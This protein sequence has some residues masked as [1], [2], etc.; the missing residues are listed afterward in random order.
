MSELRGAGD[1]L[2]GTETSD[3]VS[4]QMFEL[5][6][7][8]QGGC[9]PHAV[10]LRLRLRC[11]VVAGIGG[12]RRGQTIRP[13]LPTGQCAA[14]CCSV[15][16]G[17]IGHAPMHYPAGQ[18]RFP[19]TECGSLRKRCVTGTVLFSAVKS[20]TASSNRNVPTLSLLATAFSETPKVA[21][22]AM[23]LALAVSTLGARFAIQCSGSRKMPGKE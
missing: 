20:T 2:D 6:N 23:N 5:S 1:G 16:D 11:V 8:I 3:T 21:G 12:R 9:P 4:I 19:R 10:D 18:V 13:A 17:G 22:L 15:A 7:E 14:F